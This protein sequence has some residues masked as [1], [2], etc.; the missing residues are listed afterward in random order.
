MPLHPQSLARKL[1]SLCALVLASSA[2]A[3]PTDIER[4]IAAIRK[5]YYAVQNG[6]TNYIEDERDLCEN[7]EQHWTCTRFKAWLDDDRIVK[8]EYG[9]GEEGF[10]TSTEL[11]LDSRGEIYFIFI[12][13]ENGRQD[14]SEIDETRIYVKAG[15]VLRDIC[16]SG[17]S[18][19]ID[20]KPQAPC[21]GGSSGIQYYVEQLDRYREASGY[22]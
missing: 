14:P 9:G 10:W 7:P 3:A 5:R 13:G 12:R 19:D 20:S 11:Y 16:R 6:P 22:R 2:V 15:K 4:D 18:D 21:H 1:A 8:L 17:T